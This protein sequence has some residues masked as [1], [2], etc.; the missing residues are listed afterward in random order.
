MHPLTAEPAPAE[1]VVRAL[2]RHIGDAVTGADDQAGHHG[3]TTDLMQTLLARGNGAALQRRV[4]Q[5][6]GDLAAVVRNAAS[7]TLMVE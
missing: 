6:T 5:S 2:L 4:Y 3:L 7:H 1:T